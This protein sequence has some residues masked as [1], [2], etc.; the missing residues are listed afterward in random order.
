M[1]GVGSSPSKISKWDEVEK[2]REG[3]K[4]LED[5]IDGKEDNCGCEKGYQDFNSSKTTSWLI[6]KTREMGL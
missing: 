4:S 6:L 5:K 3:G 1:G 2:L